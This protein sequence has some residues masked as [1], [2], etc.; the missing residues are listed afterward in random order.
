MKT[1]QSLCQ[2]RIFIPGRFSPL[3]RTL[4][5]VVMVL[6]VFGIA[7]PLHV[8]AQGGDTLIVLPP[9][10]TDFP[11][12]STQIKPKLIPG[13]AADLQSDDLTVTENGRVVQV[14]S[15]EK[16]RGGVH[17]TLVINGDRRLDVRDAIGESPY[18]RIQIAFTDWA[19]RRRFSPGDTLSL[20]TQEG[21][22]I[23]NSIDRDMWVEALENYQPSF[24]TMV[25][26]LSSF[27][28]ALSLTEERV[29]PFGV[30]KAMLYIT[31]PP[32]REEIIPLLTLAE[33]AR[34]AEIQVH[35]WMLGE[36]FFLN[37]DQGGALINL[38]TT[39]G[40]QFFHYTGIEVL[41][42]PESYLEGIG[43]Y[44]DLRFDSGI[45]QEGTYSIIV[46]T[47]D[48][49]LRGESSDF[50]LNI[51]P[52]K[53]ILLS[54]PSTITRTAP[55][56]W[57]GNF[58]QFMPASVTVE[59]I[60]EFP[61]GYPRDLASSRLLIDGRIVD[62][63]TQAP[64]ES[65]TWDLTS[66]VEP[67]EY[68]LQVRVEDALGLSGET[69]LTPV[70]VELILPEPQASVSIQ[71]I[72]LIVIRALLAAAVLLLI[73]W[74]VRHLFKSTVVQRFIKKAF[75]PRRNPADDNNSGTEHQKEP[76]A[77][78]LPL[79]SS[80]DVQQSAIRI[81]R[82]HLIFGSDPD[83]ANMVLKDETVAGLHARFR[84]EKNTFWLSDSGSDEGTWINYTPI[85]SK[86]V[87]LHP[88]DLIHFGTAGFRFTIIDVESPPSATI[89][90]YN[91]N[92]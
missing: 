45:R 69:I 79:D 49:E 86:P 91:L 3:C 25:P 17:F 64:F 71:N 66:L 1:K 58:E 22:L 73:I 39:T 10:S 72:G 52:P 26:D 43:V 37:N 35:V 18:N 81:T 60:L 88:G 74:S 42:D 75:E 36:E 56:G 47:A 5:L 62:E 80:S 59:I 70:Q 82:R 89:E 28:T 29:V 90:K 84:M 8:Q 16:R 21:A 57:E 23:R 83:R 53:P 33:A 61:D 55:Q 9:D 54:P 14:I 4:I 27:E 68:S 38:A 50:Y 77:A 19:E 13:A 34:T 7:L 87:Q 65:L 24:R 44:Y 40:G 78:L 30:D 48:G 11:H 41:P 12:L 92:L 32:T 31:P 15:L 51:Q 6:M 20:V 67:G 76:F 63:R 2:G 46:E 85:G